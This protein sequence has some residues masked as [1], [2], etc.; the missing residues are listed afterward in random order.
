MP[1]SRLASTCLAL[2]ALAAPAP[3][4]TD[5]LVCGPAA[6]GVGVPGAPGAPLELPP[7]WH[8]G[9]THGHIQPCGFDP[10]PDLAVEDLLVLQEERGVS[11]TACQIWGTWVIDK[12]K[13]EESY[14]PM[15]TGAEA[16]QTA[17]DPDVALQ[18]GVEVSGFASSQFG[19][20]L[21]LGIDDAVFPI[22][23]ATL[24]GPVDFFASQPG[25]VLGYAHVN[26]PWTYKVDTIPF[27][28]QF[29]LAGYTTA[30]DAVLGTID[31]VE[32]SR[33]N[34]VPLLDWRGLYYKLANTGL[35]LGLSGGTD[36]TCLPGDVRTYAR[37]EDPP[38]TFGK[39]ID[40]LACGRT[41]ISDGPRLLEL[42]V[43]G[44]GLG[45]ELTLDAPAT[46]PVTVR[47]RLP[48]GTAE[49]G[50]L[51][52]IVEGGTLVST[53]YLATGGPPQVFT[54][55]VPLAQSTW[56]AAYAEVGLGNASHTAPVYVTVGGA[57]ICSRDDAAYWIDYL[58]ALEA[59]LDA[60]ETGDETAALLE[61]IAQARE[62]F[63]TLAA[64]D[65]ELPFGGVRIGRPATT[66]HGPVRAGLRR[67]A[68]SGAVLATC[69]GAPPDARGWLLETRAETALSRAPLEA[70]AETPRSVR[71]SPVTASG[72]GLAHLVLAPDA[73][74]GP[75]ALQFVWEGRR[76]SDVVVLPGGL[77]T[78]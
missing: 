76:P 40:A 58:D 35:R 27:A 43:G 18:F 11:V 5:A 41:C 48:E 20:L 15:V 45:E 21:A 16:S 65:D 17:G 37:I 68:T 34:N 22:D 7:L 31:F 8:A 56:I 44:A 51:H 75:R 46:V 32:T 25:A 1:A 38:L 50:L 69:V 10:G 52:L 74:P 23:D 59:S 28:P 13:F 67:D 26:W 47:L 12:Q 3:P 60:F 36:T 64:C 72:A 55:E 73:A 57:P 77:A 6:P 14:A 29:G 63:A 30:M 39:W 54:F 62:A 33:V 24:V 71:R 9:D 78:R 49:A 4:G 19:H 61:R 2:A 53:P 70:L 42:D 66:V